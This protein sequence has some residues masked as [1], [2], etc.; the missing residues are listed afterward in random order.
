[1]LIVIA[2][3]KAELVRLAAL[4]GDL[5]LRL[6]LIQFQT[7][8]I[9]IQPDAGGQTVEHKSHSGTVRFAKDGQGK[10]LADGAS[11]SVYLSTRGE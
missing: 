7:D 9:K 4:R 2:R 10:V 11:H 5:S 1:M 6:A 3:Q 8:L